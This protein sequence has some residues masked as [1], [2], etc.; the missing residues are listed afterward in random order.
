MCLAGR[1]T[2]RSGRPRSPGK[3]LDSFCADASGIYLIHYPI[4]TWTQYCLLPSHL[5]G[6]LKGIII[7]VAALISSWGL[8]AVAR[9]SRSIARII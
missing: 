2:R 3:C 1:Q 6:A 5:D 8:I 9:R 4:V 7:T